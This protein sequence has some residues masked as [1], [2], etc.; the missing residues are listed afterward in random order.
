MIKQKLTQFRLDYSEYTA[1]ECVAPCSMYSVLLD[2]GLIKDP[3]YGDNEKALREL[4]RV[5][6]VFY[7]TF[8]VD[9]DT[10]SQSNILLRFHGLDTLCRIVLNGEELARTDNMH[11][12]YTFDVK[13][14]VHYGENSLRLEFDPPIPEMEKRQ[15]EHFLGTD[16]NCFSGAAHLRK[17]FFMSGWDWAPTLP[18]MGIFRDI[19]LIA[20][21]HKIIEDI[22]V[23]QIHNDDGTVRVDLEMTTLGSD[24]MARAIATLVSPGGES[25]YCG[26]IGGKGSILL[27]SPNLWWPNGLGVQNLYRLSVNLYSDS[28]LEDSRE[29]RIGL[30]TMT[31]SRDPLPEEGGEEFAFTV[32]GVKFFSMGANYVPED[33]ILSRLNKDRTRRLLTDCKNAN[34]NS[35]RVWGG[36]FYPPD[37]FYDICDELGLVVWQDFMVACCN[38][39][40]KEDYKAN[41]I[42]EFRDN[43]RR[44]AHHPSLGL[45]SGNNEMEQ[46]LE[47]DASW[48]TEE[49][50]RDYLEL[51]ETL[52]PP[53]AAEILPDT[54][55]WPSSPSSGG[56]FDNP[57]GTERGDSHYWNV[58][59]GC[60]PFEEYREFKFRYCSEF[61]FESLPC[62]KTTR[63]FASGDDLNLFSPVMESHQRNPGGNEKMIRYAAKQYR[64][65]NDFDQLIYATQLVQGDAIRYNV[66]HMRRNRGVCMGSIYW[67]L[68]DCWPVSSWSSL[69][70]YGRWKALHYY[71]KR[72]Y[73]PVLVSA[74]DEGTRV[75]FNVSNEQRIVYEGRFSY[76][77]LDNENR[78]VFTDSFDISVP[79]MSSLNLPTVELA[80][81]VKGHEREYYIAY[82]V[83]GNNGSSFGTV[84]FVP[85]KTYSF[86][87]PTIKASIEGNFCDYTIILESD[88]FARSVEIDFET[89][90][91]V[92]EDNYFD[93]TSSSPYRIHFT[94]REVTTPET[95]RR[96]LRIKTVYDIGR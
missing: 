3:Y 69:D 9:T 79:E 12:T 67:Q 6:C 95:L 34:F 45:V 43:F 63:S 91:A 42:A 77:I 62:A 58:W 76:S 32:N 8:S 96:E 10:Y 25:Y 70:Y 78:C 93:I 40:M 2:H 72:F 61:G 81:K 82:S 85:P 59:H 20:Y 4:S 68:N 41:F 49:T 89:V 14:R 48:G 11:R 5:G 83:V 30:R 92:F 94:T 50:K 73:A 90:D 21:S 55:Y 19:E 66:E 51:Y 88:V 18:D 37:Y 24:T 23:R 38:V 16:M 27:K 80:D 33:S 57:N 13:G 71:A 17:A 7:T 84:L 44:L 65:A 56:G 1:L 26:L 15:K 31:V 60:A 75:T 29:M 86:K 22:I 46:F 64:Y 74:C 35:L 39:W 36:A 28:E 52:L 47:G 87:K 53:L 54:F